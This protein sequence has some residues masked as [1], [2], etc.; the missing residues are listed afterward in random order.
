MQSRGAARTM[1][2]LLTFKRSP[3]IASKKKKPKFY[4]VWSGREVGVFDTWDDCAKQTSG[5]AGAK[6]KAFPTRAAAEQA[7]VDDAGAHVDYSGGKSAAD[8]PAGNAAKPKR[9]PAAADYP[10]GPA[11]CVDCLLYTSPSPR[12]KRQSRMPSSA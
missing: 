2:E 1:P 4:V 6:F 9:K 11:L 7:F 8:R 10:A 12:D 5:F 3:P